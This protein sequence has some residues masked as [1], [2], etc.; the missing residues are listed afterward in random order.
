MKINKGTP[1]A[2]SLMAE[3]KKSG[4]LVDIYSRDFIDRQ[5]SYEED[6]NALIFRDGFEGIEEAEDDPDAET[7]PKN[8]L[9]F[10]FINEYK[11]DIHEKLKSIYLP[12]Q[13]IFE[14]VFIEFPAMM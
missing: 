6:P 11:K 9:I 13:N 2:M 5:P 3:L 10:I 4:D 1:Q 12:L 14:Q 7:N 8:H